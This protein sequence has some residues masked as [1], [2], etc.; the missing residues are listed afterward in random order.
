[1]NNQEIYDLV[2][3][4]DE[5]WMNKNNIFDLADLARSVAPAKTILDIGIGGATSACTMAL[6]IPEVKVYSIGPDVERVAVETVYKT[7]TQGRVFFVPGISDDI[8]DKWKEEVDMI[9]V[10]GLHEYEGVKKD[11]EHYLPFLK[12]GGVIA[13]HD[14]DLYDNTV[15]KGIDAFFEEYQF[16]L[17]KVLHHDNI[18][19]FKKVD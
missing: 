11:G 17:E 13:F 3:Q 6:A 7:K 1:M 19:A 9:F 15:G 8:Y 5:K 4:P 10:D 12:F 2:V 16:R 14:Y 18:M